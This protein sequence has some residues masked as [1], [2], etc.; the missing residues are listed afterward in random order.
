M[1][2]VL[3]QQGICM[4]ELTVIWRIIDAFNSIFTFFS[5]SFGTLI[6]VFTLSITVLGWVLLSTFVFLFLQK[7]M[8]KYGHLIF[9]ALY[10]NFL[11]VT[12][13]GLISNVGVSS[14]PSTIYLSRI[15]WNNDFVYSISYRLS[16]L[17]YIWE[18][19][20]KVLWYIWE[21]PLCPFWPCLL[22]GWFLS[23]QRDSYNFM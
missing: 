15:F 4:E 20:W 12:N 2:P 5:V 7:P 6:F 22:V 11:I 19:L 14:F 3:F 17:W 8:S 21:G 9:M 13:Q 23:S 18:G 16:V 1:F 10:S